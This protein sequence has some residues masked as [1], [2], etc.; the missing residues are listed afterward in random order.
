MSRGAWLRWV[1]GLA[2]SGVFLWLAFRAVNPGEVWQEVTNADQRFLLPAIACTTITSF[3]RGFRWKLCFDRQD[4]VTFWQSNAAYSVGALA[5]QTVVPA[6]L[7]DL[8]RIYILGRVSTASAVKA[9]GTLVIERLSDLFAVVML[10]TLL[11]PLFTLPSWIKI[12]DGFA[13]TLAVV[14]LVV[15]YLIARRSDDLVEPA[16]V[17]RRRLPHLAFGALQQ[18]MK[19]FSAVK[20]PRRAALILLASFAL[21]ITQTGTYAI[22]FMALH[23]PL[24]WKEG[25][26][27]TGVLALTAIIPTGP[28]FAGSFELATQQLLALFSVDRTL[29]TGYQEYTRLI[30]LLASLG[31]CAVSLAALKFVRPGEAE[32]P[33]NAAIPSDAVQA[34]PR[35]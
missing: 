26:L 17:A 33:A 30:N 25:G 15:V 21:W 6:R 32:R 28:G 18:V 12:A 3:L 9:L 4:R 20:D 1:I 22:S 2:V 7:G 31:Y 5:G 10:L 29:A 24:G 27:T 14:G 8:V 35:A 16:W 11:L 34:T 13:A 23:I 19:G